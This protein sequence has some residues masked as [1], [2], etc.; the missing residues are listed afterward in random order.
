MWA[1]RLLGQK[2]EDTSSGSFAG[3]NFAADI[4]PTIPW[5]DLRIIKGPTDFDVGRNLVLNAL[6]D[7]PT[8]K[9]SGPCRPTLPKAGRWAA[10]LASVTVFPYG[11]WMD[12][13]AI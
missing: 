4:T 7:I 13:R 3:D 2:A 9:L 5:W 6:W 12:S 10:S 1:V 11:L 8:G